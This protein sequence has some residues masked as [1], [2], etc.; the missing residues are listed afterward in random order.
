M[1]KLLLGDKHIPGAL[2]LHRTMPYL[3][4]IMFGRSNLRKAFK[5]CK[6]PPD[7]MIEGMVFYAASAAFSL[8]IVCRISFL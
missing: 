1:G 6:N 8:S 2:P 4:G 3:N 7:H 5:A